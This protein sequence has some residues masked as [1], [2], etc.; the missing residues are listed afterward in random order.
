MNIC[1]DTQRLAYIAKDDEESIPQEL[2]DGMKGLMIVFKIL[3]LKNMA[4]GKS[5]NDV[6]IDSLK[7][8]KDEG[9]EAV[10]YS[11]PCNIYGHGP[12]TTIGLWNNQKCN[13][14]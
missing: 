9:I 13:S 5:G 2:L 4:D 14:C 8:G 12:G 1:T 3:W 6:L 10:L 7:Q 11:H